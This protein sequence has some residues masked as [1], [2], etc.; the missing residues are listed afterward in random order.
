M[1]FSHGRD[2]RLGFVDRSQERRFDVNSRKYLRRNGVQVDELRRRRCCLAHPLNR[3][4]EQPDQDRDDCDHHQKFDQRE[5][6]RVKIFV[7]ITLPGRRSW[8]RDF[9]GV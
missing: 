6:S 1:P 7:A 3:R 8:P 9:G 2:D 5:S 4:Q